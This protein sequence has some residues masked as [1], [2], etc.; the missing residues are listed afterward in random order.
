MNTKTSKGLTPKLW[1]IIVIALISVGF[2]AVWL[3][4]YNYLNLFIWSN[5]FVKTNPFVIPILVLIFS[6]I[7]GLSQKYLRAPDMIHGGGLI[8]AFK[9]NGEKSDKSSFIGALI[10]SYSSLLSGASI[11][12]EGSIS[13]LLSDIINW[14]Q[15]KLNISKDSTLGFSNAG[16]ASA[17]NGIIGSPLFTSV[18]ATELIGDK[19]LRNTTWNLI[20]GII[21]FTFFTL[22]QLH[23]FAKYIPFTPIDTLKLEYFIYA[24]L[25]GIIGSMLAVFIGT[26]LQFSQKIIDRIFKNKALLRILSSGGIIAMVVYFFPEVMFAGET[27]IFPIIA[28]PAAYGVL[29]LLFLAVLKI[30]LMCL[31]FK[32]G[33]IG[34]PTFPILFSCI[35]VGL[36]LSLIFPTVPLSILILCI[37]VS[38]VALTLGAPL[39]SIILVAVI[40]TA[41][42]DMIALLVLSSVV[43]MSIGSAL[44]TIK[45]KKIEQPS[46]NRANFTS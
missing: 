32:S 36:A 4:V 35:M 13:I 41:D 3:G 2:T 25:L 6:L 44:K 14:F 22:F 10:A 43:G 9:G 15:K 18:L 16:L 30:L 39:T 38:A 34:G 1:Q 45:A 33:Y 19:T 24:I 11:G 37:E 23:V 27:Q 26:S 5:T 28:N 20:G 46:Q 29:M 40:G 12:P 21:G 42:P 7:V 17:Y 31:S 8:D